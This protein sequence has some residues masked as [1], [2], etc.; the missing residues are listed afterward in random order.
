[1]QPSQKI[2]RVVCATKAVTP[3]LIWTVVRSA[4]RRCFPAAFAPE[5]AT[6][7]PAD[8]YDDIYQ[9][10][11]TYQA[12]YTKSPYYF[13]WAIIV[14]RLLCVGAKSV[15][16]IGCGPGQFAELVRDAGIHTYVGLDFSAEAIRRARERCPEF[17]FSVDN[18]LT[19]PLVVEPRFDAVVSM[20]VLEHIDEDLAL[21]HRIPCG[22]TCF[23]TVPNSPDPAH[24]RTFA[25]AEAV[26]ERYGALFQDPR[27]QCFKRDNAG[28]VFFIFE[29]VRA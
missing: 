17:T 22:V 1:M 2:R 20:E 6:E 24:V 9:R 12:H 23:F 15:L 18:A 11:A 16:D 8:Y 10:S 29:G 25:D 28:N 4:V 19:S 21:V 3:P 7:Q 13:L 26:R 5:P 14:N 27:I